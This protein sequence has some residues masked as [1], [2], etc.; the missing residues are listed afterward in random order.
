MQTYRAS[1]PRGYS[2]VRQARSALSQFAATCGFGGTPLSDVVSAAGEALANAAEHGDRDAAQGFDV[3]ATFDDGRLVIEIKDHG[4][5]FD[6][7][8][9]LRN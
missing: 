6:T 8:T 3:L 1:H 4:T 2:S 7:V 9:A 5:G